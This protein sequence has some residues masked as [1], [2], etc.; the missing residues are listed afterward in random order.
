VSETPSASTG[1]AWLWGRVPGIFLPLRHRDWRLLAVGSVVSYLGDGFLLVAI[2]L[3]VF[4][5]SRNDPAAMGLVGLAWF[6]SAALTYLL[7]GYISDRFERRQ[8]MI[9][10][11]VIRA[12]VIG[13]MGLLGVSGHLRLWHV[14]VLGLCFG[15]G[16]A[17]FNPASTAIVPDL[18]PGEDL[19]KA[20]AFLGFVRPAMLYL[21]GPAL[22]GFVVAASGKPGVALLVDAATFVFSALMLALIRT[23][24]AA[25][26]GAGTSRQLLVEVR[27][28]LS[29][30]C[31]HSWCWAYMLG[32]GLS[33]L[34]W[35]GPVQ[36]L[37]PYTLKVDLGLGQAGAARQFGLILAFGGLGS[38]VVA[39]L[40]GQ[41]KDLPRRFVTVMFLAEAV[42]VFALGV[43]GLMSRPWQAMIAAL[44]ANGLFVLSQIYWTTMLQRLVPRQLL[45]R[46]VSVDWLLPTAL[47]PVS[48]A[49]AGALSKVLTAR[50]IILAGSLVGGVSM[51]A[52]LRISGVRGLETEAAPWPTLES[53]LHPADIETSSPAPQPPS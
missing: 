32:L 4:A 43:Y 16:N 9:A 33:M 30:I 7:G 8:V 38:M 12:L 45:G 34:A 6:G 44:V 35:Y 1:R 52:L 10:A 37:L 2:A 15:V 22:G 31:K 41:R 5:I 18:L 53:E 46:V 27:E 28:G 3:Q 13:L 39:A 11:D 20:N 36:V 14:V 24:P 50:S 29:F 49:L 19:P 17:L 21:A 25:Q 48:F 47:A 40:V 26:A 42:G 23:R 51:V